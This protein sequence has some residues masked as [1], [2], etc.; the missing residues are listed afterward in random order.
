VFLRIVYDAKIGKDRK[1]CETYSTTDSKGIMKIPFDKD[2]D[3]SA[4]VFVMLL[5]EEMGEEKV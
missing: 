4:P 5:P 1:V 3:W 2:I